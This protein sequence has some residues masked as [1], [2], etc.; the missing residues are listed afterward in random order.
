[1]KWNKMKWSNRKCTYLLMAPL[2]HCTDKSRRGKVREPGKKIK[3]PTRKTW[4]FIKLVERYN[5]L[6]PWR[7][8]KN[9]KGGKRG[10]NPNTHTHTLS[11]SLGE[12]ETDCDWMTQI[13]THPWRS[14][15]CKSRVDDNCYRSPFSF[16]FSLALVR[17][18]RV[19]V[20][21]FFLRSL[22]FFWKL[23]QRWAEIH[24]M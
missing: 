11:H 24:Q 20:C 23:Q 22:S 5:V 3:I 6:M 12:W 2:V 9:K 13:C 1:M 19:C 10:S 15:Q 21:A 8:N 14:K 16:P 4:C 7:K 18:A 17:S